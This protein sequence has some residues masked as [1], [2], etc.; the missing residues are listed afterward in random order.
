MLHLYVTNNCVKSYSCSLFSIKI[1]TTHI[2]DNN[3]EGFV[4]YKLMLV[5]ET[6]KEITC[7][8]K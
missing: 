1:R 4:E 3:F 7:A 8:P 2:R 6:Q 5:T